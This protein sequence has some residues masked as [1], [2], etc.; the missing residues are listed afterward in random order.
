[1][2]DEPLPLPLLES[3][4]PELL[5]L[6]LLELFFELISFLD[7]SS[8]ELL[9]M[10]LLIALLYGLLLLL[11]ETL[12]WSRDGDASRSILVVAR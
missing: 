9:S 12:L 5:L 11:P 10:T 4:E 1:L 2:L 3:S 6:S 8:S 7:E